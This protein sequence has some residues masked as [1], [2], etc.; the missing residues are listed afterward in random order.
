[1][2]QILQAIESLPEE[3]REAFNL[4]R[5]QGMTQPEAAAVIGVSART[6]KRR[7]DR[8]L[9]LLSEKLCDLLPRPSGPHD[10]AAPT[11]AEPSPGA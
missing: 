1:M 3:E 5:I 8:S 11:A 9:M 4:V 2:R 10:Q 6:V 7:L